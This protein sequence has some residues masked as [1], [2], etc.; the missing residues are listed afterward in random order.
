MWEIYAPLLGRAPRLAAARPRFRS[1]EWARWPYLS[2]LDFYDI[3]VLVPVHTTSLME[4][5]IM[6]LYFLQGKT[7][8]ARSTSP[9]KG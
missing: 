1:F 9:Y 6:V 4:L 7:D 2:V 3:K 5:G 8:L